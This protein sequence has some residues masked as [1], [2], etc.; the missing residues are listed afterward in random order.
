MAI[1]NS[2]L[3]LF[4]CLPEGNMSG[5]FHL[6]SDEWQVEEIWQ[7]LRLPGGQKERARGGIQICQRPIPSELKFGIFLH[8]ESIQQELRSGNLT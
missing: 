3:M 8:S 1:F 4:V 5:F 7:L 6:T 2:F